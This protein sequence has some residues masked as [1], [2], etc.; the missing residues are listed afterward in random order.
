MTI[1]YVPRMNSHRL[2]KYLSEQK[3]LEL[4]VL[5]T[6]LNYLKQY[7]SEFEF[8]PTAFAEMMEKSASMTGLELHGSLVL[9]DMKLPDTTSLQASGHAERLV[10][11]G[12]SATDNQIRAPPDHGRTLPVRAF[13][14]K[15]TQSLG[16]YSFHKKLSAQLPYYNHATTGT[17][18]ENLI[19]IAMIIR[20]LSASVFAEYENKNEQLL[21]RIIDAVIRGESAGV[22]VD[23]LCCDRCRGTGA[24]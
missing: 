11:L 20:D 18:S 7:K 14:G 22:Q 10:D 16:W 17:H 8:N 2:Y 9:D 21:S 23:Y 4:P 3:I 13:R 1:Y 12:P 5:I 6:L 24:C 19:L 15:W